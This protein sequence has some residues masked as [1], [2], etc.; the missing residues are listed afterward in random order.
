MKIAAG[1]QLLHYRLIG[2]IGEGG[3]GV[4]WS[5]EDTRLHR[6]VALKFVADEKA[7]DPEAVARH[8][9]EARAASA[10]NH[11]NIC[12]I[13]DIG[14]WH[15]APFIV[16]ELLEGRSLQSRIESGPTALGEAI[17]IAIQIAGALA[18]AHARGIVH[19]D[20]K[21]ANIVVAASGQAKILDFGLAKLATTPGRGLGFED[22][23]RL[24]VTAPGAL[25][26]T[27][28]YMSPEQALGKELD[29]RTDVFSL[30]VVLYELV[31]TRRPF[32]GTTSAAVFDAILHQEPSPLSGATSRIPPELERIVR[33]ALEKTPEMRYQS[34]ADLGTDLARFRRDSGAL[35]ELPATESRRSFRRWTIP[36]AAGVLALVA[37]LWP[38]LTGD[39]GENAM[40][41]PTP[42]ESLTLAVLP[43]ENIGQD[44]GQEYFSDGMT[45][46]MITVLGGASPERL[47]VIARTSSM[48]FKGS[49]ATAREIGRRLDV[50]YLVEGSVRRQ[51]DVVRI[52]ATLID[53][54]DETQ[55]WT[56][57]FDGTLEDIFGLQN[58]VARQIAEALAVKLLPRQVLA[59]GAYSPDPRAYDEY[60]TGR[61][62]DHKGTETG[63]KEAIAH[64]RRAAEIDPGYALAFASLSQTSSTLASWTTVPPEAPLQVAKEAM[65]RAFEID[66]DLADAQV[67]RA[68]Y[69]LL[70]EWQWRR[71]DEAFRRALASNPTNPGMAY[72]W[73]GHFLSFAN[74]HEEA[75]AAFTA[76]L[77]LDPLSALHRACLGLTQVAAGELELA[78][79]SLQRALEL[80]PE[81]P[82][83]YQWLG[84]LRERQ[85]RPEDA[86]AAWSRGA[87]LG[88]RTGLFIAPLGYGYGRLG[89]FDDA[90][91]IL[92][93]LRSGGERGYVAELNLARVY[94]GLGDLDRAFELLEI[95]LSKR[96]PWILALRIGP[97]F[98][99]L[100]G[101]PRFASLLRRTEVDS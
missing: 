87:D 1:Q 28:S 25:V 88:Q 39:A 89:R 100:R 30:G 3:M 5:A 68:Y 64:Y 94:A 37:W 77:R 45:E 71:A 62:W 48:R 57:S 75:L 29:A 35:P 76:A 6:Q 78:D 92:G 70:G 50:R 99:N 69:L 9:R 19:R 44:P 12:S 58:R 91:A 26:G 60:L 15:G 24:D 31:T 22:S 42:A 54:G 74:R 55:V 82:I 34:A 56:N 59:G 13:H 90:R 46:E 93:E 20:V 43:F 36:L 61:F 66:P 8:L 41:A 80:A 95:A 11:P 81:L 4:V 65:E 32:E 85:G 40:I 53:A 17:E 10:L 73:Y 51:G 98:D 86:L 14:E 33:K 21:P 49:T 101:D 67:A 52:S 63:W 83:A 2:K 47:R 7:A 96:E 18:A 72:H 84:L 16:M 27:I 38:R 79:H 23:T 97:G